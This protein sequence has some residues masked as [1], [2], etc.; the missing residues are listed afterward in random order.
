MHA[1]VCEHKSERVERSFQHSY[2][3]LSAEEV[4]FNLVEGEAVV[5]KRVD[6]V[7]VISIV[8][9]DDAQILVVLVALVS[10]G[11][12]RGGCEVVR[13]V[14]V[15]AVAVYPLE[16]IEA[17]GHLEAGAGE[18]AVAGYGEDFALCDVDALAVAFVYARSLEGVV[19]Y[20]LGASVDNEP[21]P[22]DA[23]YCERAFAL[24]DVE[25]VARVNERECVVPAQ[26]LDAVCESVCVEV[27]EA[28]EQLR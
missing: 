5:E 24:Y 17:G 21:E 7:G 6:V 10:S 19:E 1:K 13:V 11:C 25:R 4:L 23:S 18:L 15:V 9:G 26:L 14:E 3:P 8:A 28:L 22:R 27:V 12:A 16:I 20:L 2:F